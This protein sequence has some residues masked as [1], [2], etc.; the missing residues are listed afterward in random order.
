MAQKQNKRLDDLRSRITFNQEEEYVGAFMARSK[1]KIGWFFLIGPLAAFSMKQYQIL[2]TNQRVFFG[3]LSIMSKLTD[4]DIFNYDE[5]ESAS[6]K[7]GMLTYKIVFNFV[8]G[9]SLTLDAN[10]KAAVSIEG[11]VFEPGMEESLTKAIS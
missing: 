6:F 9:R 5:I 3:R 8:N 7:K 2:A 4:V 11:F 1:I 10:H